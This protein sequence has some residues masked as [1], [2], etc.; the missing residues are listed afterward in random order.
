MT[1]GRRI[2]FQ[3]GFCSELYLMLLFLNAVLAAELF[4]FE[5]I[6]LIIRQR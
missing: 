6:Y 4:F 5:V 2:I 1:K 3:S